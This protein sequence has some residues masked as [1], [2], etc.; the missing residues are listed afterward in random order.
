MERLQELLT[1]PKMRDKDARDFETGTTWLLQLHGFTTLY[2]GG[3][4][5]LSGEPD[6]LAQMPNGDLILVE[7]TIE[8]PDEGKL[9]K[10][11]AREK[12]IGRFYIAGLR[13]Q[14]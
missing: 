10:L 1:N 12:M 11:I 8:V 6:V 4:S 7:C 3:M 13:F 2:L 14:F 5:R 9:N